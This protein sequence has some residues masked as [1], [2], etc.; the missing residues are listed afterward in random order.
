MDNLAFHSDLL[1]LHT[2]SHPVTD[3]RRSLVRQGVPSQV[4]DAVGEGDVP[5]FLWDVLLCKVEHLNT[6]QVFFDIQLLQVQ[7]FP[8]TVISSFVMKLYRLSTSP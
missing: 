8:S 1:H 7:S 2:G 4:L 5:L 6:G 3:V